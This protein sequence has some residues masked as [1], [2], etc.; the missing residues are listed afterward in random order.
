MDLL[1]ECRGYINEA[2]GIAPKIEP[3]HKAQGNKLPYFIS[4]S[5][6]IYHFCFLERNFVLLIPKDLLAYTPAEFSNHVEIVRKGLAID[7]ILLLPEL[8]GY[9]RKRLIGYK[10]PFIVPRKQIYLPDL[11]IDLREH[12]KNEREERKG[13]L[14]PSAQVVFLYCILHKRNPLFPRDLVGGLTYSRMTLNRAFDE[15]VY[16]ELAGKAFPGR[17]KLLQFSGDW[18]EL[19]QKALP[20]LRSPVKKRVFVVGNILNKDKFLLSGLS[21]LS[22]QSMISDEKVMT[23][24]L[25]KNSFEELCGDYRLEVIPAAEGAVAKIEIWNY[26]P[27]LLSKSKNVDPFSLYLSLKDNQDERIHGELEAMMEG[28]AW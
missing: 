11:M 7:V 22:Q 15:L 23:Y 1:S 3:F 24:A 2:I 10:V 13:Y 17:D 8:T 21:A 19:W 16:F 4:D 27:N 20:F 6:N 12:F 25:E 26:S 28:I 9:N 14:S 18:K 5:Y